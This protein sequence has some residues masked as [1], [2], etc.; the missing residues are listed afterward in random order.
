VSQLFK[1]TA[2]IAELLPSLKIEEISH[3]SETPWKTSLNSLI[4]ITI[5]ELSKE[6]KAIQHKNQI[7]NLIKY[8]NINNLII[9]SDGSKCE[10]TGNLGAG[11]FYTKNFNKDNSG[12]FSW[13]LNTHMEVFDAELFAMEKAFKLAFNQMSFYIK[14]IWIFSDS[15][16]A[17]ER[18]QKSSLEAGQ[19]HVQAIEDW[20]TKIKTKHQ[21]NIHLSWVPGHMNIMG[22]ELADK[23]AKKG[24]KLQQSA[25]KYVSLSYIK[26]KIKESALIKW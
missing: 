20:I 25:E 24:T 18:V 23:A 10:N 6:K 13:N 4:D 2:S 8:Q 15:Q 11:I 1:I 21:V 7:Q 17:I 16:A 14:D 26:R 19:T 5:S 12:S 9:Y 22:N 3:K